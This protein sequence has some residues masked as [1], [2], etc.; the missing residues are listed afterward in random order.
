MNK[1]EQSS[2][3]VD[4]YVRKYHCREEEG[5]W[6]PQHPLVVF[7]IQAMIE[8]SEELLPQGLLLV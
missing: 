6:Q 4:E 8:H 5:N 2:L 1:C 3:A 7:E